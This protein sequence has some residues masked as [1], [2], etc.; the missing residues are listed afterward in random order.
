[1]TLMQA[2]AGQGIPPDML[3]RAGALAPGAPLIV[4]LHG[5]RYSPSTPRHDPHRHILSLAPQGDPRHVQSWPRGLGFT[6]A[7][8]DPAHGLAVAFGWEARGTLSSAYRRAGHAGA[9]LAGLIAALSQAARR[10]VAAIAHSMGARVVLSAL[11]HLPPRAMGR[12]IL[13]AGAEFRCVASTALGTAAGGSAE[14]INIVSRQNDPFD[15]GLKLMLSGLRRQALGRGLEHPAPN[16][17]DI[18][19]DDPE[20]L[21]GLAAL[22][23]AVAPVDWRP[24][25]WSP[26][27]RDGIFDFYR[28]ALRTPWALPIELLRGRLSGEAAPRWLPALPIRAAGQTGLRA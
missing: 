15:L 19:I 27:L 9:D 16:W 23:F 6:D 3:D 25:H 7:G 4:M 5:Y 26:Y 21:R 2:N 1:M 10:P 28:T 17:V 20:T 8:A 24:S 14:I 22:G 11:H 18:Q 13:L 12:A